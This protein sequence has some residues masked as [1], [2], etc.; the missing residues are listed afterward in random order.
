M[1]LKRWWVKWLIEKRENILK[2]INDFN[3]DKEEV[4]TIGNSL[5]LSEL[6]RNY[7]MS[8]KKKW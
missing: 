8:L 5:K 2:S 7:K 3:T 6:N 1:K 4:K